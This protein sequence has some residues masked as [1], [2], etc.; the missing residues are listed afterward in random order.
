M[1]RK[2]L[3]GGQI[4]A[5]TLPRLKVSTRKVRS[6]GVILQPSVCMMDD[7]S[8]ITSISMQLSET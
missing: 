3:L 5:I 4:V 6:N 7:V 1:V 2:C 8:F